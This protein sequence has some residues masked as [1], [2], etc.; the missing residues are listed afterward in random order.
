M[1]DWFTL[2]LPQMPM[3]NIIATTSPQIIPSWAPT[4]QGR[5][6]LAPLRQQ[7]GNARQTSGF[8]DLKSLAAPLELRT[9]SKDSIATSQ[10]DSDEDDDEESMERAADYTYELVVDRRP[11]SPP[12]IAQ[13]IVRDGQGQ[14]VDPSSM[15]LSFL[16]VSVDLWSGDGS[17]DENL[18]LHPSYSPT[19]VVPTTPTHYQPS[20]PGSSFTDIWPPSPR[21]SGPS[22]ASPHQLATDGVMTSYFHRTPSPVIRPAELLPFERGPGEVVSIRNLMGSLQ[23]NANLLK[24]L[25]DRNG[26]F[27]AFPDLSIRAEG[28][29]RVRMILMS[30]GQ[31]GQRH[32]FPQ[33]LLAQTF[34]DPFSVF[35]PKRFRGMLDPTELSESFAKQG[36]KL[37]NR[38]APGN[39]KRPRL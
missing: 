27:F 22:Q 21:H 6:P 7:D 16:I 23:A 24:D 31:R 9:S 3:H 14:L 34:T 20:S 32:L 29:Y 26:I 1:T 11:L 35:P 37:A 33:P 36:V 13:L 5:M 15:D 8:I 25:S 30:L 39:G 12:I 2:D 17:R 28:T 10:E 38:R 19:L 18:V 4:M